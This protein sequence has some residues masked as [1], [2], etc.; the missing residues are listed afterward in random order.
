MYRS[1]HPPLDIPAT[2]LAEFVLARAAARGERP[3]LVCAVTGRSISY[4]ALPELVDRTAVGLAALGIAKGDVCAIF[5]ANSPEYVIAVLAIV[6]LGAVVTTASPAYTKDDLA[7]QLRD[8]GA[9]VLFTSQV[10][11]P[12]WIPS[13]AGAAVERVVMF[14]DP[15]AVPAQVE[16]RVLRFDTLAATSGTLPRVTIEP[17]D[18]VALPYSSGTTGLP[19]GVML[20]HRNL[21]ANIAP[22][23]PRRSLAR[24]RGHAVAFLPF[25]HIYGLTII[26]ILGLWAGA[27]VVVMPTFELEPYLDLVER[28]RATVLHVVP[29]IVLALAK[30]P[31]VAGRDLSCVRNAVLRRRAARRRRH[32]SSAPRASAAC[33][34][35][36]TA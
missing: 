27:T 6:R 25:F 16:A 12:T 20:T 36:A 19:K 33:C 4:A 15:G 13:L 7:K 9:R 10:F 35:K 28:H 26:V 1:L 30:H 31:A 34:S 11:A 21:I 3:A 23:R 14:D 8:S 17:H 32:R 29:P 24:R 18:L 2:P 5:A 22:G